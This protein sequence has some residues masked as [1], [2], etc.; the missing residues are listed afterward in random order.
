MAEEK[1]TAVIESGEIRSPLLIGRC[2][3]P[4]FEDL[5]LLCT[6]TDTAFGPANSI[7]QLLCLWLYSCCEEMSAGVCFSPSL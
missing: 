1:N 6:D 5:K 2:Y 4:S 3:F 7:V